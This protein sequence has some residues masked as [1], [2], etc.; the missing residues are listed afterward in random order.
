MSEEIL[1]NEILELIKDDVLPMHMPGHKRRMTPVC[2]LPYEWDITE[3]EGA[4]NLHDASGIL[5]DSM[6][7]TAKLFHSERTYHLVGGSTVGILSAI[8]AAAPHGSELIVARNCHKS[9][10]H[11]IELGGYTVHWIAPPIIEGVETFGSVDVQAVRENIRKYPDSKAVVVTSPTYEGV[12]SD[13]RSIAGLCHDAEMALIVDEAHGPH[14]GLFD[15][16]GFP[17]GAVRCGADLV[18]QSAHKLLPSLTQT[19]LLHLNSTLVTADEVE[20][21]LNIFETS[22][23]SYLLLASLDG[24]ASLL[25]EQGE[26][27]FAKWRKSL[28]EFYSR[29]KK[30]R[31]LRIFNSPGG[32]GCCSEGIIYDFDPSKILLYTEHAV[33]RGEQ[34]SKILRESYR[35][36]PEM[37]SGNTVLLM[38]SCADTDAELM[39]LAGALL[40]LDRT[41][42]RQYSRNINVDSACGYAIKDRPTGIEIESV[43]TIERAASMSGEEFDFNIATGKIAVE[44][45]Y[46]YPPGVPIIAPGEKI[47]LE[48]VSYIRKLEE[49]GKTLYHSRAQG[50][51]TIMCASNV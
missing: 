44:Y 45:V 40:E 7:R 26:E 16:A 42:Y 18:I 5:K 8:R 6:E 28:R 39:R 9:V 24:C 12:L 11:A 29:T 36:E 32:C 25:A 51:G 47:S 37:S 10:Y 50:V 21:Q 4:D 46:A 14:L 30:F 27:L 41:L 1:K 23:P 3:I 34:L 49:T 48:T 33:M 2:G 31:E 38:T 35:I 20:R 15:S 13:V 19:A 22:S 17:V 43:M